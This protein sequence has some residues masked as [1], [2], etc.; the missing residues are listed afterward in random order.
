MTIPAILLLLFGFAFKSFIILMLILIGILYVLA[1]VYEIKF[2]YG[3]L[4]IFFNSE[5]RKKWDV[6]KRKFYVTMIG[7][8]FIIIAIFLFLW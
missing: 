5:T 2:L 6:K 3:I 8:F 7:V 1:G 4:L